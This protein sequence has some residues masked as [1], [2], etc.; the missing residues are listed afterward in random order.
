MKQNFKSYGAWHH[1]K[2]VLNKGHT[3]VDREL[4]LLDQFQ[5]ADS[6]NFH[7][8]N[9]RRYNLF[10]LYTCVCVEEC[11]LLT[12]AAH[13][14]RFVA[15]LKGISDEEELKYTT[16]LIETNFSNYSAWH[17]RRYMIIF[18]FNLSI[19]DFGLLDI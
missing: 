2:W 18:C 3:S 10:C 9:Y 14:F 16:K 7:A 6:R 19:F 15:A 4:Q 12:C 11:T 8:W 17:S 5:K 1:R 13:S